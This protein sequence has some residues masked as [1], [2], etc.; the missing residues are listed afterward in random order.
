MDVAT[1]PQATAAPPTFTRS[2]TGFGVV[3]LTLSLLSPGVSIV[4]SGGTI[5]NYCQTSM[6]AEL[7]SAYPTAGYNYAAVGHAIGDWAAGM[8]YIAGAF[9]L[10]VFL[11]TALTQGPFT[12]LQSSTFR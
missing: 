10:P 7:G 8:T 4:V 2:L 1:A 6:A 12:E 9:S 5:I 11:V 3:V